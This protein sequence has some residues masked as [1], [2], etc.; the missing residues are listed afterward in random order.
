MS[1]SLS[2]CRWGFF[3]TLLQSLNKAWNS[4]LLLL[5]LALNML[6]SFG[7]YLD[8]IIISYSLIHCE[9]D[10]GTDYVE[11]HIICKIPAYSVAL[12]KKHDIAQRFSST[13]KV[14]KLSLWPEETM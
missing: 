3:L 8:K 7:S 2:H 1:L 13:K 11:L 4:D 9:K 6:L 14:M 5:L 12:M 10:D